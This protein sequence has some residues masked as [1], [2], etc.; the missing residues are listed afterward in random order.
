MPALRW[1]AWL[2][3]LGLVVAGHVVDSAAL[4]AAALPLLLIVLAATVP[5]LRL[6]ALACAAIAALAIALGRADAALD[7]APALIAGLIGW[8]FLRTLRRGR[9]PLIARMIAAIDDPSQL[10]DPRTARYARRLTLLW[11]AWQGALA[12]AAVLL[13][14]RTHAFA[15]AWPALP[16]PR[17]FGLVVLPGAVAA[18][19]GAE[20]ALRPR[21][22]PQ[23]PRR[24]F[25][26][27]ARAIAR[28]WPAVL[29]D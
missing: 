29:R 14:V 22:L 28:A 10:D 1:L 17:A 23:A 26:Q 18:L 19:L 12:A 21:L 15:D 7:L 9:T 11:A 13:A 25:A 16:G 3:L 20:F 8:L 24:S 27:F 2:V 6:A 4:R 5:P